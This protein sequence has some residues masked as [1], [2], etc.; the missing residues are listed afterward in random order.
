METGRTIPLTGG[1][2]AWVDEADYATLIRFRWRAHRGG[3]THYAIRSVGKK[4][5]LMHR[6]LLNAAPR[7]EIDHR[8]LDGLNNRRSNL[9]VC[10]NRQNHQNQRPRSDRKTAFKGVSAYSQRPGL[11][12]ARIC[13][14]GKRLHLGCF[15][16]A[17]A[18]ALAYDNAARLYFGAFARTNFGESETAGGNW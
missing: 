10:S 16:S 12:R 11:W 15:D 14:H 7:E 3:H 6:Q 5:V 18:A 17:E 1:L 9:R 2:V 8:D 13:L 4:A